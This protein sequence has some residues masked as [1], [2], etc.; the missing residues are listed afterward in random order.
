MNNHILLELLEYKS[1]ADQELMHCL[2]ENQDRLEPEMLK[3]TVRLMNHIHVVD[4]IFA[5]HLTGQKQTFTSTNT[6]A[7]PEPEALT[8][9]MQETNQALLKNLQKLHESEALSRI[10]F[11]FTDGDPGCMNP[12]E[13]LLHVG[14]HSTYHRGQVSQMLKDAGIAPPRELLTRKLHAQ[15]PERRKV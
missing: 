9:A 1:W 3:K 10:H 13:M 12:T 7:T 6:D 5:A 2:C 8:W 14:V 4:C 11:Q 15:E